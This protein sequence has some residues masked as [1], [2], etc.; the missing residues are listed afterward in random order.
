MK[1]NGL[2]N[3]KISSLGF[4]EYT[5]MGSRSVIRLY[6]QKKQQRRRDLGV[7]LYFCLKQ[8]ELLIKHSQNAVCPL[9]P[10]SPSFLCLPL[11]SPLKCKYT[12]TAALLFF[13]SCMVGREIF[14][15]LQEL[16]R[17]VG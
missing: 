3:I 7:A 12:A 11:L 1:V 4:F 15:K 17:L 13:V 5:L 8:E 2:C 9:L 10:L 14:F 6:L 16:L